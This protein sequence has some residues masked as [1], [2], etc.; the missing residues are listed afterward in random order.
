MYPEFEHALAMA[1]GDEFDGDNINAYQLADFADTCQLPRSLVAKHLKYLIGKL[2]TALQE[3]TQFNLVGNEEDYFKK[4][5][6]IVMKRCEHLLK[7]N[8]QITSI[9]L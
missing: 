9:K 7:Q 1:L 4:Y 8:D 2:T 6:E 5:Q 3:E